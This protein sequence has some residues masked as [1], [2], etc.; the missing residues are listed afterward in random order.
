MDIS[1]IDASVLEAIRK[2]GSTDADIALMTPER[3]FVEYC[4][5]RALPGHGE[6]L[7]RVLDNLRRAA[8]NQTSDAAGRAL[9]ERLQECMPSDYPDNWTD[10]AVKYRAAFVAAANR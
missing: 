6:E 1:K 2:R 4:D 3:A 10:L 7:I 8:C 5:W 9:Y